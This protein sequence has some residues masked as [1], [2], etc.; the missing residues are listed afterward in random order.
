MNATKTTEQAYM[1]YPPDGGWAYEVHGSGDQAY[2][3]Y[4]NKR[5]ELSEFE[6]HDPD[7]YE[8]NR[9]EIYEIDLFNPDTNEIEMDL[10]VSHDGRQLICNFLFNR[11]VCY[12]WKDLKWSIMIDPSKV[13]SEELASLKHW[14]WDHPDRSTYGTRYYWQ[15]FCERLL[16]ACVVFDAG[17]YGCVSLAQC[18]QEVKSRFDHLCM[19]SMVAR[20]VRN[21]VVEQLKGP[22]MAH[23]I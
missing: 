10:D 8:S 3:M 14:Y 5:Y 18:E 16:D 9:Y 23:L 11:D 7:T 20:H 13:D 15:A 17:K 12:S 19:C 4:R 1:V 22:N 2:I 21:E 6:L